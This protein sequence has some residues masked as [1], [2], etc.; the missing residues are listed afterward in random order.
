M[1]V[2]VSPERNFLTGKEKTS[3][4]FLLLVFLSGK[5]VTLNTESFT[6]KVYISVHFSLI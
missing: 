1:K 5:K 6:S 3:Q 4:D 2:I